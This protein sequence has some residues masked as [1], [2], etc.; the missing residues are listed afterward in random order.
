MLQAVLWPGGMPL[1]CQNER[2]TMVTSGHPRT[3]KMA[4]YL[5]AQADP[6]RETHF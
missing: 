1:P 4:F 2:K 3:S 6:L 5:G